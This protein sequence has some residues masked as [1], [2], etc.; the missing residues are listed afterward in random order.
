VTDTFE[1]GTPISVLEAAKHPLFDV[2]QEASRTQYDM[3][4]YDFSSVL[5]RITL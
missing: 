4:R 1:V 3:H 5:I 2:W